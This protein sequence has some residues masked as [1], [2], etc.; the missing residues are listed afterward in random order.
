MSEPTALSVALT[1]LR[2]VA[3]KDVDNNIEFIVR[4]VAPQLPKD[5]QRSTL[6]LALVI[7][8]SGSM[9]GEPLEEAKRCA[10]FVR[11]QLNQND[12][13]GIVRYSNNAHVVLPMSE[14]ISEPFQE[15]LSELNANG[16]TNLMGGWESGRGLLTQINER[17]DVKRIILLSDGHL[18][19]G[20]T[21]PRVIKH[22][23]SESLRW[24]V[25]TSTYGI[26][27][28]FDEKVMT[29]MAEVGGG[30]AR[31]GERLQDLMEPF[32]EELTML[33][34]L[35]GTRV[36]LKVTPAQGVTLTCAS[37]LP[38]LSEDEYLMADLA[39]ASEVWAG[40]R[41]TATAEAIASGEPLLRVEVRCESGESSASAEGS[42]TL[43]SVNQSAFEVVAKD[44][45]VEKYLGELHVSDLRDEA[46]EAAE[47]RDWGRVAELIKQMKALPATAWLQKQ[48]E[49]LEEFAHRR[50][51]VMMMKEARMSSSSARFASHGSYQEYMSGMSEDISK[52]RKS[53]MGRAHDPD[54][55]S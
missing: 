31:Y 14:P 22:L 15:A 35:Y 10:E 44:P 4:A 39:Y 8:T 23:C 49:A 53:R 18:N 29:L 5:Y 19:R 25:S 38:K 43:P 13:I 50:D 16:F 42:L 46:A 21:E 55:G 2:P 11:S 7:D 28:R 54:Q 45:L 17:F 37:R 30:R 6:A 3:L 9:D 26:G 52:R 48:I 32:M 20:I 1:P 51:E 40:F 27:Q 34:Q 41:G 47:R 33:S 36:I 24:G 12:R